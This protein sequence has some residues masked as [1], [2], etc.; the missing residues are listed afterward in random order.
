MCWYCTGWCT[1]KF[2]ASNSAY[3]EKCCGVDFVVTHTG[4]VQVDNCLASQTAVNLYSYQVI[5]TAI[6]QIRVSFWA[7][8][9]YRNSEGEPN[10]NFHSLKKTTL[11]NYIKLMYVIPVVGTIVTHFSK[12]D[13]IGNS[14]L[15]LSLYV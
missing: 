12:H 3:E 14:V 2:S 10:L 15:K 9:L 1:S 7:S 5:M 8:V 13:C 11:R 4:T 6:N